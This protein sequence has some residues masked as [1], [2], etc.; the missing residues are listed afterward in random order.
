MQTNGYIFVVILG[1]SG[2]SFT[3]SQQQHEQIYELPEELKNFACHEDDPA[4]NECIR[5]GLQFGIDSLK[6]GIPGVRISAM[7]PFHID[8]ATYQFANNFVKGK[9]SLRNITVKGLSAIKLKNVDYSRKDNQAHFV[10]H[11]DM[12]RIIAEGT[13]RADVLINN[14]KI[15]S[16]GSFNITLTN[17]VVK[18]IMDSELYERDGHEYA[19]ILKLNFEPNVGDMKLKAD[20]LLPEPILNDAI[21]DFINRNWRQFYK[22]LIAESRPTWE[23]AVKKLVNDYTSYIPHDI[24]VLKSSW[25]APDNS[26]TSVTTESLNGNIS[27]SSVYATIDSKINA[28]E[29]QHSSNLY[30]SATDLPYCRQNK[31]KFNECLKEILELTFDRFKYGNVDMHFPSLEPF[32]LNETTYQYNGRPVS[33]H[34]AIKKALMHGLSRIQYSQIDLRKQNDIVKLRALSHLPRLKFTGSYNGNLRFNNMHIRPKGDFN[35][36]ITKME[37]EQKA[38]GI[39]YSRDGHK[40]LKFI[41]LQAEPKIGEIKVNASGIFTD[42]GLNNIVL[43]VVNQYW[44]EIYRVLLP[45]IRDYWSSLLL[46]LT[47]AAL[48]ISPF[49]VKD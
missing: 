3:A 44:R 5:K 49:D 26:L 33:G 35:V 18:I 43:N 25:P 2:L 9:I 13:H 42:I 17:L 39:I 24:L 45:Q 28:T 15:S 11:V 4:V 37:I 34:L 22:I 48:S 10:V 31:N 1:L 47:N 32:P 7:D 36:T 40:F 16:K 30:L 12:P 6:T 23:P 29:N 38:D 14:A 8:K 20:G 41:Y 21:V 27:N 46:H 19:R